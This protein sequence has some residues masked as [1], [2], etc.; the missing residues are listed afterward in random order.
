MPDL[1]QDHAN[2]TALLHRWQAGDQD[3]E[4]LLWESL[5]STLQRLARASRRRANPS[6][7]TGSLVHELYLR[8]ARGEGRRWTGREHFLALAARAMR[9]ILVDRHRRGEAARRKGKR[10]DITL[11]ALP[12]GTGEHPIDI[13]AV[14]QALERLSARQPQLAQL[15]ELRVFGGLTLEEAAAC[16]Q[17]SRATAARQWKAARQWLFLH[18]EGEPPSGAHAL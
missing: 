4:A 17:I 12:A 13:L 14:H 15:V 1:D 2:I 10:M 6:V 5:Y 8:V 9:Q 16:L 7:D 3:A 18:L 11:S